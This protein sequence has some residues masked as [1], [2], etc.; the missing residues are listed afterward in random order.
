[1]NKDLSSLFYWLKANKLYLNV[2]KTELIIFR[3]AELKIDPPFKFTLDDLMKWL[4]LSHSVKYLGVH[5]DDHLQLNE[6]KMK[7]NRAIEILSKLRYYSNLE[8]L[9]MVCHSLFGS[10]LLY[11]C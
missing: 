1:M 11:D 2:Q 5:L 8:I 4:A 3:P 6:V 10:H 9:K 7:L